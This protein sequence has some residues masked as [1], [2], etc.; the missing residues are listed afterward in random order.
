MP[1]FLGVAT[2]QAPRIDVLAR[3]SWKYRESQQILIK[4]TN[5]N[6]AIIGPNPFYFIQTNLKS[7]DRHDLFV[8][9]AR[10]SMAKTRA[11][12]IIGPALWNQFYAIHSISWWA[13]CLFSFSQDCS[14]LSESIAL[15]A[16]Q[17]GVHCKKRYIGLTFRLPSYLLWHRLPRGGGYHT[18]LRFRV[19]FKNYCIV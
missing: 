15:E 5:P 12:A 2:S 7:L 1:K 18:P 4:V 14:L 3:L 19:R 6:E 16:L 11:L 13:K 9:R 17:I 8:P 10:T